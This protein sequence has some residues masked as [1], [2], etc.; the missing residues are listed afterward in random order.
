MTER[1]GGCA[2]LRGRWYTAAVRGERA[3]ADPA[4]NWRERL[5]VLTESQLQ[6]LIEN[7][8]NV[9][10]EGFDIDGRVLLWNRAAERTFGFTELEAVGRTLDQLILDQSTTNE[11]VALLHRVHESGVGEGPMQWDFRKR[12]GTIGTVLSTIVPF[13]FPDGSP[14]F[15]CIDVDVTETRRTEMALRESEQRFRTMAE[16]AMI[17]LWHITMDGRTVYINPALLRM[18]E[19]PSADEMKHYTYHDFFTDESLV[20]IQLEISKRAQGVASNYEVEMVGRRGTHRNVIISGAPLFGEDGSLQSLIGTF[21]DIT[22]RKRAEEQMNDLLKKQR[23]TLNELDHRVRNNLASLLT[24]IDVTAQSTQ[25]VQAFASAIRSRVSA[26][27]SVHTLLSQSKWVALNI[28]QICCVLVPDELR[29][30]VL[31]QGP[32]LVVMPRQCTPLAMVLQELVSNSLKHGALSEPTGKVLLRWTL[33]RNAEKREPTLSI[34]WMEQG[35]PKAAEPKEYGTGLALVK[36]I[37]ES[38]LRG[39]LTLAFPPSGAQHVI[40]FPLEQPNHNNHVS[41]VAR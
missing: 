39:S 38:D 18:L 10:V 25:S 4:E 5:G 17:G 2:G 26:M 41:S 36:G 1:V 21:T 35:G 30:A 24:L 34:E 20:R 32:E 13:P 8:P 27:S 15:L 6:L 11:F 40:H 28:R 33:D 3:C 12:D 9:A 14:R 37:V 22:E 29:S 23:G 19:V 31:M 16:S 7:M